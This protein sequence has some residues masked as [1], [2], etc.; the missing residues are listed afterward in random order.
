MNTRARN[1]RI[2]AIAL[3]TFV[4][5]LA[6]YA[7]PVTFQVNMSVQ[8]SM[9]NFDAATDTVEVRGSFDGWGTGMLLSAS[10]TNA[11]VYQGTVEVSGSAGAVIEYKFVNN[12]AG[13]L[14]W[15]GNVG[16]GG[17]FGNRSFTLAD[18]EQVL[19]VVYFDSLSV[20]PGAGVPVTFRAN[21]GVQAA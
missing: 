3:L 2:Q 18:G 16:T 8:A 15:E 6:A 20:D 4:S 17:A 10:A 12:R 1:H 19:P 7:G 13:T 9:G 11:L 5:A 21:L 14:V